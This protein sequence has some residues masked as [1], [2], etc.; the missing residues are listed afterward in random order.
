MAEIYIPYWISKVN[1]F[2]I[3]RICSRI[4]IE[5]KIE[6]LF[7]FNNKGFKKNPTSQEKKKKKR[8]YFL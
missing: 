6:E 8:K 2:D 1:Y 4:S 3:S 5:V 7:I